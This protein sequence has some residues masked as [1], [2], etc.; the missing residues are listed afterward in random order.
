MMFEGL[1]RKKK[2]EQSTVRKNPPPVSVEK[3]I[4]QLATAAE[5]ERQHD[6]DFRMCLKNPESKLHSSESTEEIMRESLRAACDFYDAEFA[7]ILIADIETEA[8]ASVVCYNRLT[9]KIFPD[10]PR[11]LSPF[12]VFKD[13]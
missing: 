6:H 9:G 10:T 13:G 8:W 5:E 3:M 4:P 2:Q 11:R 1:F 12:R 7:A